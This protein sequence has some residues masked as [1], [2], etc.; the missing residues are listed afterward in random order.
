[1]RRFETLEE[2]A[3]ALDEFRQRYNEH[4]LVER[5]HFQVPRGILIRPCLPWRLPHNENIKTVGQSGGRTDACPV[6]LGRSSKAMLKNLTAVLACSLLHAAHDNSIRIYDASG[7][8]QIDRPYTVLMVFQRGEFPVGTY[9]KPRVGGSAP[10]AW[11]TDVKSRWPDGSVLLAF[12]S[13]PVSLAANGNLEVDFVPDTYACHLGPQTV[14]E[15]AALDQSGMLKFLGGA[16]NAQIRGTA[17]SISYTID[18]KTMIGNGDWQYWLRG[19]VVTRVIVRKNGFDYDFGWEWNGISWQ[20]PTDAKYRSLHPMFE[21]SFYPGWNGVETGF[22]VENS[23]WRK[24]QRQKLKLEYLAGS[25]ATA[26]YS[27]SNYDFEEKAASSY[28]GWSGAEPGAI[29]VDRNLPYL[30]ATR[31]LP[32]YDTSIRLDS[33]TLSKYLAQWPANVG[34]DDN[35]RPDPRSCMSQNPCAYIK[36]D[37]PGT[38]D[39][40]NFGILPRFQLFYLFAMGDSRFSVSTKKLAFDRFILGSGD[41]A[42][43]IPI[44]YRESL[45]D[46]TPSYRNYFDW[47]DDQFT[48]SFG[49]IKSLSAHPEGRTGQY[50]NTGPYPAQRVCSDCPPRTHSWLPDAAHW[51]SLYSVPY[52]L[53]GRW[54]YLMSLQQSA[55][56]WIGTDNY[57]YGRH[58]GWGLQI[59]SS[60]PRIP[61]RILK[62]LFWAFLLSPE[63]PE[64]SY[65]AK[66]IRNND[67]A[68]EGLL[69][70]RDGTYANQIQADCRG[71]D[72]TETF[73]STWKNSTVGGPNA[74][75]KIFYL[76]QTSGSWGLRSVNY[77]RVNG[78]DKTFG[79]YGKDIGKEW[80]W[81]P[82]ARLI[83][84]DASAQPLAESDTLEVSGTL[85]TSATPW[86]MG[87]NMRQWTENPLPMI[88]IG[89]DYA[90][91]YGGIT[92]TSPWMVSYLAMH[93]GWM[94]QTR[95]LEI[96]GVAA[97]ERSGAKLGK[98]YIDGMLHPGDPFC[99]LATIGCPRRTS[100][101]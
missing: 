4:R 95:A 55:A 27:K 14:C 90:A 99:I 29:V 28:Y 88:G 48:Q 2:L 72:Y 101:A 93:I 66:I 79:V 98:A 73:T 38:G 61:A 23:W 3:E 84:Q 82:G 94:R 87:F 89:G 96:N 85:G 81:T 63:S 10:A 46:M 74:K 30:V 31:V 34:T 68:Y 15:S 33:D 35:N 42:V 54:T 60:N 41:A 64:R 56:H 8:A 17:N 53:T 44:H 7:S 62:E 21:L 9:P 25:P 37:M 13:F 18:A 1:M 16:W 40:D 12:V 39:S 86:C 26:I 6:W 24:L 51:P 47:P 70:V 49:R 32:P 50:D 57:S 77:V 45:T 76:V 43:T 91:D 20:R 69:D 22:R 75:R 5:L 80:Y 65:F 36:T 11:Q 67:A 83:I 100:L 52:I 92:G 58:Y 97:F 71:G 78:V 59:N 19:P